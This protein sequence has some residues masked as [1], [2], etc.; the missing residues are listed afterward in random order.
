VKI[1]LFVND[2]KLEHP[3]FTTT[4]LAREAVRRGHEV[5]YLEAEG[6]VYRP[7][8]E[9]KVR[10]HLPPRKGEL[11]LAAFLEGLQGPKAPVETLDIAELDVL[12]LRND[13]ALDAAERPWAQSVG[14]IFGQMA[15][16]RGVLVLND[17]HG[18]S[19]AA[20][21]LYF[22]YFPPELRPQTLI[23]R[24]RREIRKFIMEQGGDVVL[25]PLQGSGGQSVFLAH[26]DDEANHN[27]MI[28]AVLRDGYVIAQEYLPAAAQGDVRL[29]LMD[30]EPLRVKS[31][32]AMIR[33]VGDGK[34]L[35]SNMHVGGKAEKAEMDDR[36][37][38]IA[39]LVRPKLV[40][41]GMFMV[42]LDIAGDKLM[43]VNVF[44]PGGMY[45]AQKL[46][47][48]NFAAAVLASLERKVEWRDRY[49]GRLE[50]PQLATL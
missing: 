4:L 37:L 41:D 48:A 27:Q 8:D 29:F 3:R 46:Q 49:P 43:E 12:L 13:P 40:E 26:P 24:S 11:S 47:R 30:G 45:S 25:K 14:I 39:E 18:L 44:T 33:R 32:Y 21:K 1:G 7:D 19:K 38:R 16:L 36:I 31:K 35:R 22:Q 17:P 23:S 2:I 28:D 42:G 20:N 9:L 6:F 50:N 10:T 15:A 34:D 5:H